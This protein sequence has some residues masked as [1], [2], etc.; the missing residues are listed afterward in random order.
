MFPFLHPCFGLWLFSLPENCHFDLLSLHFVL[1]HG[2]VVRYVGD[3]EVVENVNISSVLISAPVTGQM[4][5]ECVMSVGWCLEDNKAILSGAVEKAKNRTTGRS[6][7][8]I[9]LAMIYSYIHL[10]LIVPKQK[11]FTYIDILTLHYMLLYILLYTFRS[12]MHL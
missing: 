12:I 2:A 10:L 8:V 4:S 5:E 3:G 9:V 7:S 1:T 11:Y 6:C